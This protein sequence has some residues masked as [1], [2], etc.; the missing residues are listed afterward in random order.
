MSDYIK[1]ADA[2][3]AVADYLL[4]HRGTGTLNHIQDASV[5]INI[6]CPSA[7]VV[8]RKRGEWQYIYKGKWVFRRCSCCEWTQTYDDTKYMGYR[9]NFCPNCGA[10][11]VAEQ[12]EPSTDCGWK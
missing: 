10:D 4:E 9:Y 8:E 11:M 3:N 6:R 1:R 7:D 2:I 5:I 12:T